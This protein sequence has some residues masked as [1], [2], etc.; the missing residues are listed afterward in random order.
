MGRWLARRLV[1]LAVL[2][3][4]IVAA[5]VIPARPAPETLGHEPRD[6]N[7]RA[8]A[9]A[10]VALG[11]LL[12]VVLAVTAWMGVTWTGRWPD[13][14]PPAAGL[15]DAPRQ[16]SL[17]PHASLLPDP[18]AVVR[19]KR[20][21]ETAALNTWGWADREAGVAVIP[22]DAAMDAIAE[23][24]LPRWTEPEGTSGHDHAYPPGVGR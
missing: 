11:G 10:A 4:G 18:S 14:R 24:G 3:A 19:D 12:V 1:G 13:L 21:R 2:L 22:I 20:Q 23:R 9:A 7:V 16:G 5:L 6:V 15:A 17:A 8:V